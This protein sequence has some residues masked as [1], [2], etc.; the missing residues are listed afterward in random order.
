MRLRRLLISAI[1]LLFTLACLG[2]SAVGHPGLVPFT[3]LQKAFYSIGAQDGYVVENGDMD[4]ATTSLRVGDENGSA[5]T[6]QIVTILSFDTSPL[7]D[8]ALIDSAQL[9][10]K[11]ESS[12]IGEGN[13][14]VKFRGLLI[15]MRFGSFGSPALELRDFDAFAD[16][17]SLGPFM[18]DLAD[19]YTFVLRGMAYPYINRW[20]VSSGLTQF[21]LRFALN[22][23]GNSR[24]DY[25]HFSS[26]DEPTQEWRPRLVIRYHQPSRIL[27]GSLY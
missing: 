8:D 25:I 22:S 1:C 20:A 6:P 26:G 7:P 21:R 14:F 5:S 13:P 19:T 9:I 24:P 15:D 3:I 12:V 27:L 18:P 4:A 2:R 17:S 10:L 23:D 16:V 11:Q